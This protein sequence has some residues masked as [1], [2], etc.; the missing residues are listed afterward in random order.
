MKMDSWKTRA[1][2]LLL[3][4][5][6]ALAPPAY[7]QAPA[8]AP[9]AQATP[10][11]VEYTYKVGWGHQSEFID[12]FKKNHYPILRRLKQMGYI[13]EIAVAYPMNHAGEADRW[14]M[15]V[16]VTFRDIAASLPD[17]VVDKAIIAELYPDKK[18]FEREE[19]RRFEL[20]IEHTDVPVYVE[21]MKGWDA[22][23]PEA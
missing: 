8:P 12:L 14:D 1:C 9:V 22:P 21:D 10:F 17:P 11:V 16:T 13:R 18:T 4:G 6:G 7:A 2:A 5:T 20:L 23:A 19:Q 15:R 3:A